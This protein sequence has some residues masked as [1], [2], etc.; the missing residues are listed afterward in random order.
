MLGLRVNRYSWWTHWRELADYI[1]PRRYKWLITPNQQRKPFD[2][3]RVR[4]ALTLA[5]DRW[6]GAPGLSKVAIVKTVGGIV[7]PGSPLAATREE[8]EQIERLTGR[9]EDKTGA[10]GNA[11]QAAAGVRS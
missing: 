4:R 11:R 5:V 3:V 9:R 10:K 2:D 6:N 8:L 1:L 7:F